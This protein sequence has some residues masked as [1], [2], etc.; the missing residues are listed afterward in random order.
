MDA[1]AKFAELAENE[2]CGMDYRVRS[3]IKRGLWAV[4]APHGGGIEP[5]PS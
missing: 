4:V 1:Y 3:R 5:G 2:K